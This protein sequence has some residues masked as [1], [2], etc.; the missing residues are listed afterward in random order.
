MAISKVY[1]RIK[2]TFKLLITFNVTRSC[3]DSNCSDVSDV[4][5]N[6][7]VDAK[8]MLQCFGL[9]IKVISEAKYIFVAKKK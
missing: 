3:D 4:R 2:S 6:S 9:S 1:L 8:N 7:Y 5:G